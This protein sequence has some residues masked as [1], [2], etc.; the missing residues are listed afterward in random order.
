MGLSGYNASGIIGFGFPG[1]ASIPSSAGSTFLENVV[2]SLDA[3]NQFFAY[4]LG[5]AN[6]TDAI[7]PAA[8]SISSFTVGQLDSDLANDTTGFAFTN[9]S[10]AG[11]G[12]LTAYNY[13][14]M[15]LQS[16][17]VNGTSIPL[18]T[19]LVKDAPSGQPIAVLDTGTT[20]ILGPTLDVSNFWATAG[21]NAVRLNNQSGNWEVRCERALDVSFSLG[22]SGQDKSYSV[23]P[24]DISWFGGNSTG[25]GWC[26]GGVQAND[27]VCS[28]L[29]S[30]FATR[31]NQSSTTG[32]FW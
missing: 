6:T 17:Y 30:Y 13:W 18:S 32:C 22:E 25:D 16:I 26:L 9:V 28:A 2:S 4:K 11:S 20:L 3:Q 12:G 31:I 14:K 7:M 27:G 29:S 24:E 5:R 19:S 10:S 1:I 8:S 15:P 23:H 21:A